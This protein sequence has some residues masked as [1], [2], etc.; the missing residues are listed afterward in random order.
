MQKSV[1]A[2]TLEEWDK[3]GLIEW[4]SNNNPRKII[5]ADERIGKR[6]QDIWEF[7]DPAY[8]SYP[9]EKNSDLLDLI[10]QTSSN[11]ESIVLDCFCGSGTTLYSAQ[12]NGRKWIGIDE[13]D[14]AIEQTKKK[15]GNLQGDLFET[16]DYF[17]FIEL[18]SILNISENTWQQKR[19][20]TIKLR[21][22]LT[23]ELQ[24]YK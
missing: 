9:T 13:S 6:V 23:S 7:K 8:P 19:Q 21:K 2:K 18:S 3:Q 17:E 1:Y 20:Q 11:P 15:I 5:Y 16:T 22:I 24:N 14:L 12:K 4:S 10:I